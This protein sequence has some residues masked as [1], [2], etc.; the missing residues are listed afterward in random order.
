MRKYDDQLLVKSQDSTWL[1][2]YNYWETNG[3]TLLPYFN[4]TDHWGHRN[5]IS[6]WQEAHQGKQAYIG[7]VLIYEP[8]NYA[9][10]VAYYHA[11]TRVCDYPNWAADD[12]FKNA[13][14][15]AFAS[16]AAGSA[17]YHGSETQLGW[18]MT[19]QMSS[20]ILYLGH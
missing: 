10:N 17:N 13:I 6:P 12:E 7:K 14:K 1:G 11:M 4:E 2:F 18:S 3:T 8:C 15:R 9:S 5:S 20:M 16:F 19:V